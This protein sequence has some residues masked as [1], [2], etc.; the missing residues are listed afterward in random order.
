MLLN[1]TSSGIVVHKKEAQSQQKRN[2]MTNKD[3][4]KSN[5]QERII[6]IKIYEK[7]SFMLVII[8]ACAC[9]VKAF[10][11]HADSIITIKCITTPP[12]FL[13]GI[14]HYIHIYFIIVFN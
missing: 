8:T 12:H 6:L 7:L 5:K 4:K 9:H 1:Q 10:I 11:L 14:L 13:T 2:R 3:M